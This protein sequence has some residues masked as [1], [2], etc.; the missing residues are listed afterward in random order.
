M[1]RRNLLCSSLC[2]LPLD[3]SL[4]TAE[5][6]L[7]ASSIQSLIRYLYT[8]IRPLLSLLQ[9]EKYQLSQILVIGER[10]WLLHD[11]SGPLLDSLHYVQFSFVLGCPAPDTELKVW[12]HQC[13]II[14]KDQQPRP[15]GSNLL[16]AVQGSIC[17]LCC[18]VILLTHV[19]LGVHQKPQ[20]IYLKSCFSIWFPPT[21]Y[22]WMG[23]FFPRCMILQFPLLNTMMF[24]SA[25]FFSLLMMAAWPSGVSATP[26]S[27][28]SPANLLKVHSVQSSSSLMKML[29]WTGPSIDPWGHC[30]LLALN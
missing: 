12:P 17:L 2:P 30:W 24:L 14:E 20:G 22:C 29:H 23:L 11:F 25:H 1:F 21:V 13:W 18:K 15:A 16:N 26:S 19:Q 3:L 4:G 27:W 10:F 9:A 28:V 5:K 7:V 8:L 6:R